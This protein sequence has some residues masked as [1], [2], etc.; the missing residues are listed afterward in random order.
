MDPAVVAHARCISTVIVLGLG[1]RATIDVPDQVVPLGFHLR[2]VLQRL[3]VGA[4]DKLVGTRADENLRHADLVLA[5]RLQERRLQ[6]PIAALDVGAH[7][8]E[9]SQHTQ[10]RRLAR[11]TGA[12]AEE[13]Q[14]LP[15]LGLRAATGEQ[16]HVLNAGDGNRSCLKVRH[17]SLRRQACKRRQSTTLFFRRNG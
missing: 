1:L 16:V 10:L 11:L 14:R 2:K 8:D 12:L 7:V 17:V 4:L 9:A 3:A 5:S 15:I 13:V 6:R